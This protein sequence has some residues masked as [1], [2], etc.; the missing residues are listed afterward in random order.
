MSNPKRQFVLRG[1]SQVTGFRVFAFEGVAADR[2]RALYSVRVDMALT[3]QYGI[4]LQELPLLCRD[5]LDRRDEDG[6]VRAFTY[7]EEDMSLHAKEC[8][9]ARE[10]AALRKKAPRRP[11][12]EHL[13][14]AWRV[15][16]R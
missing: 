2:T 16:P 15:P 9:A 14:A 10:G 4:R 12:P 1:F 13:G 3:R 11:A 7:T 8:A 6:G 5:V